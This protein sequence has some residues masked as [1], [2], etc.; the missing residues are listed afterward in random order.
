MK[1]FITNTVLKIKP[2]KGALALLLVLLLGISSNTLAVKFWSDS[3]DQFA[4]AEMKAQGFRARLGAQAGIQAAI[5]VLQTAPED[6]LFKSG[7]AFNPPDLLIEDCEPIIPGKEPDRHCFVSYR[8]Q[9]ENGRI[10]VNNLV[11]SDDRVSGEFKNIMQ[12]LFSSFQIPLD[13]IDSIIDWIDINNSIEGNG[14]ETVYYQSLTPPKKIKNYS[15]FSLSEL[16]SI[17]GLDYSKVYQPRMPVG[18][19]DTQKD[20]KFQT[21]DEKDLLTENDWI[22]ANN[23]TAYYDPE[24]TGIDKININAARYHVLMSL[25]DS[26]T[27]ETV[28]AIFK[29]KRQNNLYIKD[30][31]ALKSLPEFNVS[32]SQGMTLYDELVGT[33]GLLSGLITTKAEIY[34]I[35]GIGS[36]VSASDNSKAVVRKVTV[37]Y[38]KPKNRIIF[39]S[40]D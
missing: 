33:G 36:I 4:L 39:Y 20:L 32:N 30:V 17:K 12:R 3:Q 19:K 24:S 5:A 16:C 15:L 14:G 23:L 37:L 22:L 10:N 29:L 1:K 11:R 7:I 2:R 31:S 35:V 9:P 21:E 28:L 38:D 26:M 6:I 18:W 40:E 34:R 27:R 13:T 25:S 8:I